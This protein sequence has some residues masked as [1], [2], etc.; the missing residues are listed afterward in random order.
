M[1]FDARSNNHCICALVHAGEQGK[2][3]TMDLTSQPWRSGL[4]WGHLKEDK[5]EKEIFGNFGLMV[6]FSSQKRCDN[7]VIVQGTVQEAP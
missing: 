5:D 3:L 1:P 7:E 6:S 4:W 2:M